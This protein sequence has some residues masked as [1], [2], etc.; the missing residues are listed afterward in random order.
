MSDPSDLSDWL[1][2]EPSFASLPD[3]NN[4]RTVHLRCCDTAM[5]Q[6]YLTKLLCCVYTLL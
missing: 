2:E 4:R 1:L 5:P 6:I 3:N